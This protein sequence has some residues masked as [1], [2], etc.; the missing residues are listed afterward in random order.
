MRS[1]TTKGASA[2][3]RAVLLLLVAA[4]TACVQ[5]GHA[6]G[7]PGN[8]QRQPA[9][10]VED[11]MLVATPEELTEAMERG[12]EILVT[13]HLDLTEWTA[14]SLRGQVLALRVRP[15]PAPP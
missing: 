14:P 2:R 6:Q 4:G 3:S 7:Q 10:P 13:E 9:L 5:P 1:T 8:T 11:S 15:L 12:A